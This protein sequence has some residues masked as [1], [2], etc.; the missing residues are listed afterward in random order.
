MTDFVLFVLYGTEYV[1]I[2]YFVYYIY[3]SETSRSNVCVCNPRNSGL[4]MEL[5]SY[6]ISLAI[7]NVD[8]KNYPF[9]YLLFFQFIIV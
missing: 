9:K 6:Y 3:T 4:H 5:E 8:K 7:A 2:V 1:L